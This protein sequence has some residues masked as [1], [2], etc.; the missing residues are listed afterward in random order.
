MNHMRILFFL[1]SI[2]TLALPGLTAQTTLLAED[3]NTCAFPANWQVQLTGNPNPNWYVGLSQNPGSPGQSIDTT[4]FLFIDDDSNGPGSPGYVLNFISPPFDVTGFE[5][6]E[7]TMDVFF[8]FGENDFIQVLATDGSTETLLA[9]FDNFLTNG[10]NI[11]EEHFSLRHDLAL[12]SQS[13]QTRLIIR[14]TSPA[15]SEGHYAG[16]D[17]IKVVGS[18]GGANI[19]REAFNF[20]QKPAGWQTELVS[21]PGDWTFG[22]V[23]LGSSA[24]YSGNSM[25]GSCFVFFD[26]NAQGPTAPASALRLY[27]PWFAGTEYYQYSLNY[28]AIMRYSGAEYFSVT[29]ENDLGEKTLLFQSEGKV[30]GPFFPD[31]QHFT[32]DLSP[33]RSAQMRLIFEYSDGNSEGYWVGVDNVKVTGAGPALDF[34]SGAMPLQTGD[35]CFVASNQTALFSGPATACSGRTTGSLWFR[36][37][38]DFTGI[39]KIN[40]RAGF[41]DVVSVYTGSCT[42]PQ[43]LVCDNRN[44]HGFAGETTFFPVQTGTVY[45]L[46]VA[47]QEDGYGTPRG[48]LCIDIAPTAAYPTPPQNDHCANA[49]PLAVAGPCLPGSNRHAGMSAIQPTLNTLARADVWY[50]FSAPALTNDK[51]L[52]IRSNAN[53]S[54]IIT[55]YQGACNA[56]QEIAGNHNGNSLELIALNGGQTYFVQ[57]AGNFASIEG[58]LCPEIGIKQTGI[59]ANDDCM[60]AIE[61][62][63][64]GPCVAGNNTNATFSGRP[65]SCAVLADRDIWFKFIA[66]DF[67]SVQINTGA[68]FEHTL[69]VWAGACP[70]LQQIFCTLNPLR[71]Q[72]FVQVGSLNPGQTYYVQIASWDGPSGLGSGD[73][74]LRILNGE[75]QP[76]FKPLSVE[77]LQPCVG[78]DSVKLYVKVNDG[79]LPYTFKTGSQGQIVESGARFA[80][81]V[82]DAMGC[83]QQWFDTAGACASN[84][85]TAAVT[86]SV[87]PPKC[88]GDANGA[89]FAGVSGASGALSFNWSNSKFT[90]LNGGLSAGVYTV[91]I[92]EPSGCVYTLAQALEQPDSIRIELDSIQK[93]VQGLS[94]GAI[95]VSVSGGAGLY[96][97]T[98]YRNDTLL[99]QHTEDLDSIPGGWYQL[100]VADTNGCGQTFS[101]Q[102]METVQTDAPA[103]GLWAV[104]FPNPARDVAVLSVSLPGPHRLQLA[105]VDELGRTQ[106]QRT[107]DPVARQHIDIDLKGL[108]AG[109]YLLRVIAGAF[110]TTK[111]IVIWR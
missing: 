108:P 56:L 86:M 38:A 28:D 72:G 105:L 36:W 16:V 99:I 78:A 15:N 45:Y 44:E 1:L 101:Y 102:L 31:Y 66:P 35:T 26:D 25:D 68:L 64:G 88:F 87:T 58:D 63:V 51:L 95:Q 7:C 77:V 62:A 11:F 106:L 59:V 90:A 110:E 2:L 109:I 24:F 34:C 30:A 71:C 41:N 70:D 92:T 61:V 10:S 107:V 55:V 111:K 17:N 12:V 8:R 103:E 89:L 19:I 69:A 20:C 22:R 52:E 29:L 4:C 40:T 73:V 23:P 76:D 96:T 82:A 54:D 81:I 50:Q 14:Y 83:E 21:G 32:F 5:T 93:P 84:T 46:R 3:F 47:G 65:P 6:V 53:F 48:A 97:Y 27:S 18:G 75:A 91:T 94:N 39:A 9:R 100:I 60:A 43:L 42:N 57:I 85:C 79:V 80:V 74:C 104:L 33:Y 49:T 13:P 98:W 67:G 37:Q